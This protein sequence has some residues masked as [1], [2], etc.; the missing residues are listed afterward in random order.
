VV[1]GRAR[2][3]LGQFD[4]ALADLERGLAL[5]TR[6]GRE[7]VL[8][9]LTVESVAALI[10]L[11]R[12]AAA[13][14]AAEDGVELARLAANPRMLL[15]AQTALSS[16]RLALGDV[17]GALRHGQ[18]ATE[19]GAQPDFHAA[20]LPGWCMGAALVAAGNAERGI[21]AMLAAFGGEELPRV[22]PADRPGAAAALVEARLA[23]DDAAGAGQA[24][25]RG[26]QAARASGT[27]WAA[28]QVGA[29]RAAVLL[30]A[31]RPQDAAATA[32]EA[33]A[34]AAPLAA[35]RARLLEGRALAAAGRRRD[36]L[37]VLTAAEEALDGFGARRAR[38]EA[39]R[40]LRQLGHRV[41]RA[42]KDGEGGAL[43]ARERE[44]ADLVAA[45]RTNREIA[46]QLVLSTRTIEAHL[47]NIFA[48]LGVRSRV[49]LARLD[50]P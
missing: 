11:G 38:D 35:A 10:E 28:A 39:V 42:A 15:W 41:V 31:G 23:A 43:T 45:G 7:R 33:A 18:E 20:G 47:R 50:H 3:A 30:A 46:A 36:A 49:E 12:L 22:L 27:V 14:A 6:T 37:A 29:A 16:A 21:D 19:G 13:A 32:R 4:G 1:L 17:D 26:E 40:E 5:A 24:V 2:R 25:A 44:I 9:V 34:V 48:K 8:L